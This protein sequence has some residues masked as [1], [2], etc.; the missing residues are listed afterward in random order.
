[1]PP[2]CHDPAHCDPHH[3]HLAAAGDPN[4]APV[5][6]VSQ[7]TVHRVWQAHGFKP[8]RPDL[9]TQSRSPVRGEVDGCGRALPESARQSPGTPSARAALDEVARGDDDP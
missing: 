5:V 3:D 2:A 6:G 8:H 4:L 1:M 9:P 7:K